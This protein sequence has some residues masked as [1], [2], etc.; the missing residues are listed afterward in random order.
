MSVCVLF[1]CT[2]RSSVPLNRFLKMML[3]K[4]LKLTDLTMHTFYHFVVIYCLVQNHQGRLDSR[5]P[6]SAIHKTIL[7]TYMFRIKFCI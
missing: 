3:H 4:K 6:P 2:S 7:N 5:N 1:E